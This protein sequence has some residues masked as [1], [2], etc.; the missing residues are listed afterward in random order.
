MMSPLLHPSVLRFGYAPPEAPV[1]LDKQL[2]EGPFFFAFFSVTL[3]ILGCECGGTRK[4]VST[5]PPALGNVHKLRE[6]TIPPEIPG[7]ICS[8]RSSCPRKL[9][10]VAGPVEKGSLVNLGCQPRVVFRRHCGRGGASP[11][12]C[13][14]GNECRAIWKRVG[15]VAG[16]IRRRQATRRASTCRGA[17]R[18]GLLFLR[19]HLDMLE[20]RCPY[21][22]DYTFSC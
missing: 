15:A 13:L 20:N 18:L 17:W 14:D 16:P 8:G 12:S 3:A 9:T 4:A 21:G 2:M 22:P 6:G 5:T 11:A 10:C 7:V 1:D 19:V